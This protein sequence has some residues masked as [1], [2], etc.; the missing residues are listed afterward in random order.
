[1]STADAEG[2]GSGVYAAFVEQELK[3]ET[4]RRDKTEAKAQ[5]QATLTGSFLLGSIAVLGVVVDDYSRLHRP[6]IATLLLAALLF[7]LLAIGLGAFVNGNRPH[8][9][10]DQSTIDRMATRKQWS[11]DAETALFHLTYQRSQLLA[12][13]SRSNQIL[14]R[15]ALAGQCS[16]F[17]FL[18]C[19]AAGIA[20][21]I[22]D[23]T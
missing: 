9:A 20:A 1:M 12:A 15:F 4:T 19:Y 13:A 11:V 6:A 22:I 18:L 16:Q 7:A 14:A 5:Q 17:A 3:D 10:T 23:V 8:P 21:V 2:N